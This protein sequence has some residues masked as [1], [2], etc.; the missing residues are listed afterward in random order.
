MTTKNHKIW[1]L[2]LRKLDGT[3]TRDEA[4]KFECWLN[5]NDSNREIFRDAQKIW[6]SIQYVK[7]DNLLPHISL[8]QDWQRIKQKINN[9]NPVELRPAYRNFKKQRQKHDYQ[10]ILI[11]AA[12]VLMIV[13]TSVF[14]T[15]QY[16]KA[17]EVA[18]YEPVFRVV[19]TNAGERA[20]IYLGDG[21]KVT[22]NAES[23]IEI[24]DYSPGSERLVRMSGQ[25]FFDVMKNHD[26]LFFID[27]GDAIVQVLGT[28]FDVRS[29]IDEE[30]LRVTVTDGSVTVK[31]NIGRE[32]EE[33]ITV[34]QGQLARLDRQT[35]LLD[36]HIPDDL[37]LYTGW[38]EGRLI[39]QNSTFT[40]AINQVR[41]WF[42]IEI[43][44]ELSDETL[45]LNELT[46]DLRMRSLNSV[47]DAIAMTMGF[48]YDINEVNQIT[49]KN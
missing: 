23:T 32:F 37:D 15:L 4:E 14:F 1:L 20:T 3:L 5:E 29:Y 7:K 21:S 30:E 6:F 44:Y 38:V 8:Q 31:T 13:A 43:Q 2:I 41:R 16:T 24:S 47:L 10:S 12:A 35:G 22:L 19:T 9:A 27:T 48:E 17:F 26:S 40:Y 33:S 25:A 42:N 49:I 45:L 39:F 28:S 11:K 34:E 46:A 18:E 36:M